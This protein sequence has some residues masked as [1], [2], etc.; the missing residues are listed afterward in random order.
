MDH[1]FL[2]FF[3]CG[4]FVY[5]FLILLWAQVW[6]GGHLKAKSLRALQLPRLFF[7]LGVSV[8][9]YLTPTVRYLALF[10]TKF[11][12]LY[13]FVTVVHS[14]FWFDSNTSRRNVLNAFS[15]SSV[16]MRDWLP[17]CSVACNPNLVSSQ[18]SE[19]LCVGGIGLFE[20]YVARFP[21]RSP[22]SLLFVR[23]RGGCFTLAS[24]FSPSVLGTCAFGFQDAPLMLLPVPWMH[25]ATT[26]HPHGW[27]GFTTS[28]LF[29]LPKMGTH[30]N[31]CFCWLEMGFVWTSVLRR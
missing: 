31:R 22:L 9:G 18:Q 27:S 11:Y 5:C 19:L 4:L 24:L 2:A 13:P 6:H 16:K 17:K 1:L 21:P 25:M 8:A 7:T 14:C 10:L 29:H 23:D 20:I 15:R 3:A 26:Q 30:E 12:M 28:Q